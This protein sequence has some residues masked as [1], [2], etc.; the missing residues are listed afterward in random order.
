MVRKLMGIWQQSDQTRGLGVPAQGTY[1]GLRLYR[2]LHVLLIGVSKFRHIESSLPGAA[3]DVRALK[4][5]LVNDYGVPEENIIILLDD[6]ATKQAI[7]NALADLTDTNRVSKDD[8]VLVF[9][10]THGVTLDDRDGYAQFFIV[11]Y[12][13]R[14]S[15]ENKKP[16][17][18]D[19]NRYCV[20]LSRNMPFVRTCPARQIVLI[21]DTCFSGALGQ[22][23]DLGTPL[24]N[25]ERLRRLAMNPA[26]QVLTAGTARQVVFESGSWG[27][28]GALAKAIVDV[29]RSHAERNPGAGLSLSDIWREAVGRIPGNLPQDPRLYSWSGDGEFVLVAKSRGGGGQTTVSEGTSTNP[30]PTSQVLT[31]GTTDQ[32]VAAI[33]SASAGSEIRL[34]SGT[35]LLPSVL[36]VDKSLTIV[37]ADETA[38]RLVS[39]DNTTL[40]QVNGGACNFR[41]I[42][43]GHSSEKPSDP[44]IR[45]RNGNA[46]FTDCEFRH[47]PSQTNT[48]QH[49]SPTLL[50]SPDLKPIE[51]DR[52]PLD[53]R[54]PPPAYSRIKMMTVR[55]VIEGKPRGDSEF[56]AER[57]QWEKP[58]KQRR[59]GD[60]PQP[61]EP[62]RGVPL[63]DLQGGRTE[64]H[65]TI[66]A[67]NHFGL[68]I[69]A[70]RD[71]HLLINAQETLS[72]AISITDNASLEIQKGSTLSSNI[73]I[74][75]RAHLKAS[76]V[77][78]E[79][80]RLELE[81]NAQAHLSACDLLDFFVIASKRSQ[82]TVHESNLHY[83][84]QTVPTFNI[85]LRGESS[86]ELK[87]NTFSCK[88]AGA[89]LVTDRARLQA[90][91][92]R[93][94]QE[95]AWN[96]P[97]SIERSHSEEPSRQPWLNLARIATHAGIVATENSQVIV[98]E[99]I[100]QGGVAL[101]ILGNAEG[102][103]YK[104]T[105]RANLDV[106]IA[107]FGRARLRAVENTCEGVRGENLAG[108]ATV[109]STDPEG[110]GFVLL[111]YAYGELVGNI[112]RDNACA[113]IWVSEHARLNAQ[114]NECMRNIYGVA[115]YRNASGELR[116]NQCTANQS[117]GIFASG[118]SRVVLIE[119]ECVANGATDAAELRAQ[120]PK[121]IEERLEHAGICAINQ[122]SVEVFRNRCV[123]NAFAGI[124]LLDDVQAILRENVCRENAIGIGASFFT[125]LTA[126]GNVCE[127][128]ADTG[129]YFGYGTR[130][131][132]RAN[133]CRGNNIGIRI[134]RDANPQVDSSNRLVAN[135]RMSLHDERT[136]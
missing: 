20:A 63:I 79:A 49:T 37:S 53:F 112:C 103:L 100:F 116:F 15:P 61:S 40:L 122:A 109:F 84:Y 17:P 90:S 114:R 34:K 22:T 88:S 136:R 96:F 135:R 71:A 131:S 72:G 45:V 77:V 29:L 86:S 11:P 132:A 89:V 128:N 44:L 91:G 66:V 64:L 107:A 41:N 27:Q 46:I 70:F 24:S 1:A 62:P 57:A 74:S 78:F 76:G 47:L 126:E 58:V 30:S 16:N 120:T 82:L 2:K 19:F 104:N 73:F 117:S 67:A 123:R 80:G 39:Q 26:V 56:K 87:G 101:L 51:L 94:S 69:A 118:I 25:P 7:E 108:D 6:A 97:R 95:V 110:C 31:V 36:V 12:D 133:I 42:V 99:N 8:A 13:A 130:G 54:I 14:V 115:F 59:I 3:N 121:V 129:I 119:N 55:G 127:D 106:A 85:C 4:Q 35:Y 28:H 38:A 23:R 98:Q 93:F 75:G 83:H 10:A 43:F 113:G 32:L 60:L 134:A 81:M 5:V 18:A 68:A 65:N 50:I 105:C 111:E 21:V 33:K 48:A 102:E 92:N 125:H 52:K 9:I 124:G